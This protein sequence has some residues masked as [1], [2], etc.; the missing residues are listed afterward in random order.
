MATQPSVLSLDEYMET[1]YSPECEY[2][3]GL[4]VERNVGK[5]KHSYTQ[6]QVIAFLI[7]ILGRRLFVFAGA[8]RQSCSDACANSRRVRC[9]SDHSSPDGAPVALRRDHVARR[10]LE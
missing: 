4:V 3:D 9:W 2:V 1:S 5:F 8:A 6:G 10:S 7:G